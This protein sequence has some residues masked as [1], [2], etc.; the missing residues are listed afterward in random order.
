[1]EAIENPRRRP[2]RISWL[3]TLVF[4]AGVFA[5]GILGVDGMGGG[6]ALAFLS[7]FAAVCAFIA[8]I[9][10]SRSA[11]RAERILGGSDVIA[12]WSYSSDEWR[13]FCEAEKLT[14]AEE[15]RALYFLVLA[16]SVV[17][18]VGFMLVKRDAASVFVFVF[19]MV[20]MLAL[21]IFASAMQ[22]SRNRRYLAFQGPAIIAPGGALLAGEFHDFEGFTAR[23]EG[24]ECLPLAGLLI[25]AVRYSYSSRAGRQSA[26]ARLPVPGADEAEGNRVAQALLN[27]R[28]KR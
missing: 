2:A 25:L 8:A 24:V 19:L 18:G 26:V 6:F 3:L 20:F 12:R 16:I 28:G 10:F 17:V 23:V 22:R 9:I 1:M 11:A 21:R 7:A 15:S 4:G 13:R 27:A 14:S 5:P